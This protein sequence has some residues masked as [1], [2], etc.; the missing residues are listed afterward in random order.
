MSPKSKRVGPPAGAGRSSG[1]SSPGSDP[2]GQRGRSAW[3]QGQ[4]SGRSES[5]PPTS[6]N[7][8]PCYH[9]ATIP[10]GTRV[11]RGHEL[12]PRGLVVVYA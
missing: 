9:T 1:G 10:S 8:G 5:P 3:A 6:G 4:S 2:C 11:T 7:P 12:F